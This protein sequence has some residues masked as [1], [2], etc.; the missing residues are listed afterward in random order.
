MSAENS[1]SITEARDVLGQLVGRV[2]YGHERIVLTRHG[3]PAAALVPMD[4]HEALERLEDEIDLADAL[5]A[6]REPGRVTWDE[7]KA[8]L[9]L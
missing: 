9:K 3:R 2:Q 6:L 4:D 5:A 7:L 1:T 8:E